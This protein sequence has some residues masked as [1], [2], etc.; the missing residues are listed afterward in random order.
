MGETSSPFIARVIANIVAL[1]ILI[2]S[3]SSTVAK[4]TDQAMAFLL[5]SIDNATLRFSDS[6]FESASPTIG[7]SGFKITAAA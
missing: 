4:A 6:F 3:I 2:S 7:F 1:R 5:I